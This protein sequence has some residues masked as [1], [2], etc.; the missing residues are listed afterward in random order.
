MIPK[1]AWRRFVSDLWSLGL[2]GGGV[3]ER[4]GEISVSYRLKLG[5]GGLSGECMG[6]FVG[7]GEDVIMI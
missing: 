5:S 2:P 4:V 6:G 1:P 3:G 7:T